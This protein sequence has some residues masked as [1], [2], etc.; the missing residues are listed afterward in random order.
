MSGECGDSGM[1]EGGII[2]DSTII[3]S[4]IT[5]SK[6][7]AS[8]FSGGSLTA[9]NAVDA[10]SAK[11]ILNALVALGPDQL[12]AL[13]QLLLSSAAA[14]Q[15]AAAPATDENSSLPTTAYGTRAA[16]MG[17]PTAWGNIAGYA[18]PLYT[19]GA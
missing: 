6:I 11:T 8:D 7:E 3:S 2:K 12:A 9:L 19:K 4:T 13:G 10:V 17:A 1:I 16:L 5:T 14:I 18:V 15:P